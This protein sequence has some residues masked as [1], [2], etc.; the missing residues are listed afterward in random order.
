MVNLL[1]NQQSLL[2]TEKGRKMVK[3]TDVAFYRE[4]NFGGS[5][6]YYQLGDDITFHFGDDYNDKYLSL[7]VINP[8]KVHCYQHT[9]GSGIFKSYTHGD[10]ASIEE[11]HGLSKFQIVNIDTHFAVSMRLIDETGGEPRQF[12]MTFN[13]HNIGD[14]E[15]WSG[16]ET[17]T[18]LP[19]T[20]SSELITCAIYIRNIATGEYIANGSMY[21]HYNTT[22][23]IIDVVTPGETF[24]PNLKITRVDST[25][26]DFTLV[27]Q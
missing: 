2:L 7:K 10:Y 12:L 14:A 6:D 18:S 16:E 8:V 26:F 1:V 25:K 17:Y 21:F 13:A 23:G 11:M 15:F 19:V 3:T 5:P 9:D 24:P 4:K 22:H 27:A 20:E